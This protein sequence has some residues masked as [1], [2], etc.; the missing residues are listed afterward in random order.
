MSKFSTRRAILSEEDTLRVIE[1]LLIDSLEEVYS[2]Y[3]LV[4]KYTRSMMVTLKL[5]LQSGY[6]IES[7]DS[8]YNML[9][10]SFVMIGG[11]IYAT[12]L[13]VLVSNVYMASD[14]ENKLE[15]MS[16][17]IDE[18]CDEKRLSHSLRTKIKDFFRFKFAF[19][20]FDDD[21]IKESM[22]ANLRKEIMLHSCSNLVH[23]VPLFQEIP[24]I[25]L[26]NII[27]CLKYEVYF[28]K[29]VIIKANT[30]GESMYFLA[31]GT[32]AIVSTSGGFEFF[33]EPH[34]I[35]INFISNF[36]I[37]GIRI[38]TLTDGS[39]FGEISLLIKRQKRIA[40]IVA[41]EMCEVFKL[42]QKDFRKVIEPNK[43]LLR[44]LEQVAL[45]RIKIAS[46]QEKLSAA[47]K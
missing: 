42:T 7:S 14:S 34:Q 41:L 6:G 13:I 1:D 11:W 45:E 24:Q 16:R 37:S 33:M 43:D 36:L 2:N 46:N 25:L 29:D 31:F 47:P 44:R 5:G 20:C 35:L 3:T 28:P 9:L 32:A 15:E 18:F 10:T 12:Y 27:S 22:P 17:E 8:I 4:N 23:K 26:E 40:N 19:Q 38:G 21:A 30:L 39:H